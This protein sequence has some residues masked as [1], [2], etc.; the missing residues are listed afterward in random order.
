MS[1]SANN[2]MARVEQAKSRLQVANGLLSKARASCGRG[3][4][5]ERLGYGMENR[6]QDVAGEVLGYAGERFLEASRIVRAEIAHGLAAPLI[7]LAQASHY[8][9]IAN[10][11]EPFVQWNILDGVASGHEGLV[12]NLLG[13]QDP[14]D[15]RLERTWGS[16]YGADFKDKWVRE[17]S[18][19]IRE[20][21]A[22]YNLPPELV[23]GVIWQEAGVLPDEV[24]LGTYTARK[25]F[26]A[27]DIDSDSSLN[28]IPVLGRFFGSEEETSIGQSQMQI[29]TAAEIL[30]YDS[31]N[32]STAQEVEIITKLSDPAS[33][34]DLAARYLDRLRNNMPQDL[35]DDELFVAI[36][37]QYNR[38]DLTLEQV[39]DNPG[40]GQSIL[41][42][43]DNTRALL[44]E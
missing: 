32:L 21:A 1:E 15:E 7:G 25:L 43:R 14:N 42:L 24:D 38:G 20:A 23:A 4:F 41:N 12:V 33:S 34:I 37:T 31:E 3:R 5:S 44:E 28:K 26:P 2:L 13:S 19:L 8:T 27:L 11:L 10:R 9:T 22:K 18:E 29:R 30:D 36:A 39:W 17:H 40:Y 35:S 6:L 16:T